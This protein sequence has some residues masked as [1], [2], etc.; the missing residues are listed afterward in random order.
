MLK[1]EEKSWL[2][3][4]EKRST[5]Q[6]KENPLLIMLHGLW[7]NEKDLFMF[8]KKLWENLTVLSVQA[9]HKY[10]H[11]SYAWFNVNFWGPNNKKIINHTEAEDSRLQLIT[12]IES[13]SKIYNTN[14]IYILGFS[15][16][17][18]IGSWVSITR[19]DLIK[20]LAMFSWRILKQFKNKVLSAEN[21]NNLDILI[22]HAINDTVL[23]YQYWIESKLFFESN[24]IKTV[25][26]KFNYGHSISEESFNI[27]K[28]WIK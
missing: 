26:K 27:F 20:W 18:I 21:Y 12:F 5:K 15:Q 22:I 16:W 13:V 25:M 4:L 2:S 7:S 28:E 10:N 3:F 23:P 1:I 11:D 19:P 9:P 6:K 17:A 8:S 24:D 14:N